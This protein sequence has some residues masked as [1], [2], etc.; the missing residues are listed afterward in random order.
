M[1]VFVSSYIADMVYLMDPWTDSCLFPRN[2][3]I[4]WNLFNASHLYACRIMQKVQFNLKQGWNLTH[5]TLTVVSF[6]LL[7][8]YHLVIVHECQRCKYSPLLLR[9]VTLTPRLTS[10]SLIFS[11]VKLCFV[12]LPS[13][14]LMIMFKVW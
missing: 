6:C 14:N 2:K 10:S 3:A 1:S 7:V 4:Y 11:Q 12:K 5:L 9:F 13:L 8:F